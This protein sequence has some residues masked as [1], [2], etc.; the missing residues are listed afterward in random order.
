MKTKIRKN[1]KSEYLKEKSST[2]S[3]KTTQVYVEDT[4]NGFGI[5]WAVKPNTIARKHN[6]TNIIGLIQQSHFGFEDLYRSKLSL[7]FTI[8]VLKEYFETAKTI[9]LKIHSLEEN[10][11]A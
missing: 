1:K 10:N 6:I 4:I 9:V 2:P 11:N 8:H 5:K 3:K 7:Y